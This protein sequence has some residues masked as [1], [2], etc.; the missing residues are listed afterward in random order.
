MSQPTSQLIMSLSGMRGIIGDSLHPQI[1]LEMAMAFGTFIGKKTVIIGGDTRVSHDMVKNIVI[2]GLTSV[3]TTVIDIGKVTTPTVQHLIRHHN[4]TGGIVITASHNPIMWN[5]IKLMNKDGSFLTPDE[6]DEYMSIYSNKKFN[7]VPWNQLGTTHYDTTATKTHIDTILSIIPTDD[8]KQSKLKVLCDANNGAGAVANPL[9]FDALGIKYD[10]IEPDP[11]GKFAHDPEPL[12]SNLSTIIT[13]LKSG[14]YDIGFVQDADADRLVILD[15]TGHFIGEDYSLGFCIDY[16][17]K[18]E[19]ITNKTVVVNLSTSRVIEDIAKQHNAK[20]YY[21]IIGESNVTQGIRKHNAII[22]GEGNG[23]VIY[24]KVGWGRD[25][26]VGMVLALKHL[27]LAQ[28]KVS[29][30]VTTYPKYVMVRDKFEIQSKDKIP[31]FLNK[32][33]DTFKHKEMDTQDGIKIMF[34]NGWVHTRASNTEPIIRIFAEAPSHEE[35]TALIQKIQALNG[36]VT[37]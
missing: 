14:N 25:S 10:I 36:S 13:Q 26:L 8:I 35:A 12:K 1:P 7:L 34:D 24:P 21:T 5:G 4:A 28:K 18:T 6:Y 29:E 20:T 17:L 31:L 16:I 37:K 15:E 23:G 9:L 3:G 30:I 27:V 33:K 11:S 32:V 19:T 2:S 22:G